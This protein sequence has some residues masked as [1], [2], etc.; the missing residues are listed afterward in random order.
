MQKNGRKWV[1]WFGLLLIPF[2]A[3]I[4][5]AS[6]NGTNVFCLDMRISGLGGDEL[7]CQSALRTVLRF[8]S[9]QGWCTY[10]EVQAA[11]PTLS[12]WQPLIFYC[13]GF[14]AFLIGGWHGYNTFML[15]NVMMFMIGI[16]V[17]IFLVRPSLKESC[18][19]GAFFL[20]NL[21]LMRQIWSGNAEGLFIFFSLVLSGTII[22]VIREKQ[23]SAR[24]FRL[25][26][27][28][29]AVISVW[30][31]CRPYALAFMCFP[32]F[33]A[34]SQ[35]KY[36]SSIVVVVASLIS[37]LIYRIG[38][39]YGSAPYVDDGIVS[40]SVYK[41]AFSEHGFLGVIRIVFVK[42][43]ELL[44]LMLHGYQYGN[45]VNTQN[46]TNLFMVELLLVA[47]LLILC[48]KKHIKKWHYLAAFFSSSAIL[49]ALTFIYIPYTNGRHL[50][51]GCI[52]MGL[53]LIFLMPHWWIRSIIVVVALFGTM[54]T[55]AFFCNLDSF[56]LPTTTEKQQQILLEAHKQFAQ[57][58]QLD[59]ENAWANTVAWD[60]AAIP[61]SPDF[62]YLYELPDGFAVSLCWDYY[63][64]NAISQNEL[65]SRYLYTKR[66]SKNYDAAIQR[67]YVEVC[68]FNEFVLL[69]NSRY[70][71]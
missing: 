56:L 18:W 49:V 54:L 22:A 53:M 15:L 61:S 39:I 6:L 63:L 48:W 24:C 19:V 69:E 27:I 40:L 45:Q 10:N 34:L 20:A 12:A 70:I 47:I 55:C 64:D 46:I 58:L 37:L 9:P 57:I 16:A 28:M 41:Q 29:I 25:Y 4:I 3:L 62:I 42:I 50:L 38:T 26:L 14:L 32:L 13:Y 21:F 71:V 5:L 68:A 65:N 67:Q 44:N 30:G 8:F 35:K 7:I 31:V 66:S 36:K 43:I 2:V 59:S 33:Y 1:A 17:F 52:I 51:G 11:A 60:V 23:W